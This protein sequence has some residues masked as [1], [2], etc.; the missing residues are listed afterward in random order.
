MGAACFLP[1]RAACSAAHGSQH[2]SIHPA[3]ACSD[4]S[5]LRARERGARGVCSRWRRQPAAPAS[6]GRWRCGRSGCSYTWRQRRFSCGGRSRR[7]YVRLTARRPVRRQH[8]R[9]LRLRQR[10]RL[11]A[12]VRRRAAGRRRGWDLPGA[13][14]RCRLP[15][16][17]RLS[18][19]SRLLHGLR[20]R[21][22]RAAADRACVQ[23]S[24]CALPRGSVCKQD[25]RVR[26]RPVRGA[27]TCRD[28]QSS[29][30]SEPSQ[31]V[32][33]PDQ[34]RNHPAVRR[35][36]RLLR[37]RTVLSRATFAH[38]IVVLARRARDR[39]ST[40]CAFE[41]VETLALPGQHPIIP[42]GAGS[43]RVTET[44]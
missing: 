16:D 9:A 2:S 22:T 38:V 42:Q 43:P 13:G 4:R 11:Q 5:Q 33:G 44:S 30:P 21:G 18:P 40:V 41:W 12:R 7:G 36:S 17:S 23:W 6:A 29:Q 31:T 39:F 20:L 8:A 32:C 28:P 26:L 27:L 1:C 34:G 19:A 35:V 37:A 14:D 15:D 24:G 25:E 3:R 10:P